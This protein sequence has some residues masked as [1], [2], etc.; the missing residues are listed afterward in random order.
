MTTHERNA[1]ERV[2]QLERIKTVLRKDPTL[3]RPQLMER[4]R[5][6]KDLIATA[7]RQLKEEGVVFPDRHS[8][9]SVSC[10][11]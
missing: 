5:T 7:R 10:Y 4:F 8:A 3:S 1:A 11:R 6:S 2:V 9:K